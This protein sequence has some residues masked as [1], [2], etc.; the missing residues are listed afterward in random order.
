MNDAAVD[1]FLFREARFMDEGQFDEW[2]SLWTEDARYWVP[3]N[4]DDID[5]KHHVSL[6]YDDRARLE[7][8]VARLKSG[9]VLALQPKPRM[10]RVITNVE[11]AR[12]DDAGATVASNFVWDRTGRNE[13]RVDGPFRPRPPAS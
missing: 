6:I 9:T 10:R 4:D 5:P 1:R 2:L 7:Q 13:R 11:I 12:M 3:C 8:R